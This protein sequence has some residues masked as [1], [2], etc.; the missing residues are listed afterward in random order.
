MRVLMMMLMLVLAIPA[1][2]PR[3]AHPAAAAA[4]LVVPLVVWHH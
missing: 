1:R 3:N 4:R 2:A